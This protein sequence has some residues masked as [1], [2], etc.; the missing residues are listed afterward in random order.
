MQARRFSPFFGNVLRQTAL[1]WGLAASLGSLPALAQTG[2]VPT[3]LG[4]TASAPGPVVPMVD[5]EKWKRM[6]SDERRAERERV[7]SQWP[8]MSDAERQAAH[9]AMRERLDSL[10]PEQR[11]EMRQQLRQ[12]GREAWEKLPPEERQARREAIRERWQSMPPEERQQLRDKLRERRALEGFPARAEPPP[13][14]PHP[15]LRPLPHRP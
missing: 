5:L 4:S 7:R 15:G 12:E 8:R 9:Q 13:P 14:P 11:Q 6:T 1:V 3:A 10:S 2:T